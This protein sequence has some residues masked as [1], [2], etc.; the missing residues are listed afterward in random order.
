MNTADLTEIIVE[1]LDKILIIKFNNPNRR[2]CLNRIAY[3]EIGKVL[4]YASNDA[5][6][7]IV[8]FTGVGEFYSAGNDLKPNGNIDDMDAYIKESN[9]IFINMMRAFIECTK[10]IVSLVNGPCIGVAATL[11]GLSD[12]VWCS[13]KA[14]FLC[15]FVRLGI[16]PESC[17]TYLFPFLITRSKATELL[18]MGEKLLPEDA[19]KYGLVTRIFKMDEL[20][21]IIWPKLREYSQLPPESLLITKSLM[22][23]HEKEHLYKALYKEC[24]E[25]YSRFYSEVFINAVAQFASRKS[26]I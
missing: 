6:I 2:N 5:D 16:V 18:L 17:S 21:T 22:R 9:E 13:D 7:T 19:F 15:P 11:A 4:R 24:E 14:Y 3:N 23:M 8:V 26:K 25:L 10:V 20:D 12:M 1:K